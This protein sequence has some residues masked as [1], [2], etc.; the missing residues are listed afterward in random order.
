[1]DIGSGVDVSRMFPEARVGQ[2]IFATMV[3]GL[4]ERRQIHI[5][6]H[7]PATGE[8]TERTIDVYG[9]AC[10]RGR[11]YAPAFCHLRGG[12]RSFR[13]DRVVDAQ[14]LDARYVLHRAF[15]LARWVEQLF[16]FEQEGAERVQVRVRL[17]PRVARRVVDDRFFREFLQ[18][19]DGGG[20]EAAFRLP[21][22]E[23]EFYAELT[24]GYAGGAEVLEPPELRRQV[25][26]LAQRLADIHAEQA[27][28]GIEPEAEPGAEV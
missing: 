2:A 14:L 10:V 23:L 22:S 19:V 15:D 7:V 24:L 6:Y 20:F 25:A 4:R 16:T 5:R 26:S 18:R 13:L 12:L 8:S 28:A 27:R 11:W 9:L 3:R 17:S 21:V 1:M